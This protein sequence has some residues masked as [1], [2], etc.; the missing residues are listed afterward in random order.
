MNRRI[1]K[2]SLLVSTLALLCLAP[3]L[4]LM[5]QETATQQGFSE[6]GVESNRGTTHRRYILKDLGTLGGPSSGVA[7]FA[8]ILNNRGAVAGTADTSTPDPFAPNCYA[9]NCF[10]Q[11]GFK[12]ER[13]IRTDLGALPGGSSAAVW[14][15]EPGQS[16]GQSQ[17]G[18]VDP[19]TG[20]PATTAVIWKNNGEIVNLGNRG[21]NQ[22]LAVAINNGG[23][24]IGAAANTIPDPFSLAN[25][26]NLGFATQTRAFLW[27]RGVMRDLG[28]LGGPD[29]FAQYLNER[30]QVIGISYTNSTPN[31]TTGIPTVHTFLWENGRM[32]DLGSLGG[33]LSFPS[34][35]N[36]RGQVIGIMT[37]PG[38]ESQH[39]FLWDRGRLRDLGTFGGQ[40]GEANWL[41]DAGEVVGSAY[42]PG[43]MVRHA[44]VLK[45]GV[46][47]DLG[48]PP[49]FICTNAFGINSV[50]QVV[51][52]AGVCHGAVHATLWENGS[53]ID[54]NTAIPPNSNLQLVY[55]LSINDGGEIAG[56]GVPPGVD[57]ADVE[58]LGHAF[59]LIPIDKDQ[60]D[61]EVTTETDFATDQI[62]QGVGQDSTVGTTPVPQ[63]GPETGGL[64]VPSRDA[65]QINGNPGTRLGRFSRLPFMF[66]KRD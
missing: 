7:F 61:A 40:N 45:Q 13:G 14:I 1:M 31:D 41:N 66:R 19:L 10:V 46:K 11:H 57:P 64:L 42:F 60:D 35:I 28:T 30:G 12:W 2:L 25:I 36:S 51:G 62:S 34:D 16:A 65:R 32:T 18:L 9:P 50:G 58:S 23:Q 4:R 22:G 33:T 15:N 44:F 6:Q 56:I 26:Y 53:A 39:P 52:T 20:L 37:L 8:K 47:K 38:D 54:L 48:P 63:N 49:G 55:A 59:F 43:D 24:V 27:Q 21:G 29:A 17:N 3:S 5:A